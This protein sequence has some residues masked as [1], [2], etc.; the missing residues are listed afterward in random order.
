MNTKTKKYVTLA[1]LCAVA[2]VV[3]LVGRIPIVM[4]LSYDPKDVIIAISGFIFGPLS[5]VFI[6]AVVSVIEMVTVSST[7]PIGC[8]MNIISTCAFACTAAIIYKKK[9]TMSGAVMGLIAGTIAMTGLMLLWNYFLTPIYEG[10]PRQ[11]IADMLVPIFLPF[12]LLKAGLNTAITLLLYK[13][14]VMALRKTKLLPPSEDN[15]KK[16][17]R[18]G[19]LLVSLLLLASCVLLVL[20]W[21]G[22]I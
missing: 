5:V 10:L 15:T 2:Y 16:K 19:L 11:A 1:M 7:G 17:N 8:I 22:I 21:K 14:I 18:I 3:M 20:I 4:F 12:N 13:P 6:S 9:H